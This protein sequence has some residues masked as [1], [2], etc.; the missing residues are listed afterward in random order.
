MDGPKKLTIT[1]FGK[2]YSIVTDENEAVVYN[3]A[4][5]VDQMMQTIVNGAELKDYT[6]VAVLV[7]L[8]CAV[9][10]IKQKESASRYKIKTGE[11]A[12]KLEKAL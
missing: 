10:G 5:I 1:I 11:L 7:A 3:A 9:D 8:Q 12:E 6:K 4:Q 2:N